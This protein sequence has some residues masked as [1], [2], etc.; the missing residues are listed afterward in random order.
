MI[1]RTCGV[2]A[3]CLT[4]SYLSAGAFDGWAVR[5]SEE[6]R[7]DSRTEI[8]LVSWKAPRWAILCLAPPATCE[9]NGGPE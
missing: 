2:N 7:H 9:D 4:F 6:T 8:L 3:A 1:G 5:Q